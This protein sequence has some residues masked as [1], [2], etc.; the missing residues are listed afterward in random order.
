MRRP[1]PRS[2]ASSLRALRPADLAL[3]RADDDVLKQYFPV[4]HVVTEVL[5]V[6]KELL[7]VELVAVPR[8]EEAGGETWHPGASSSP[9]PALYMCTI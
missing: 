2:R 9:L 6:Y 4:S 3:L 8:T 5:N 7:G 1:L